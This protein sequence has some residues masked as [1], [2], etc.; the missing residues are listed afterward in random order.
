MR[1]VYPFLSFR[2]GSASFSRSSL[3]HSSWPNSQAMC[4]ALLPNLIRLPKMM[5]SPSLTLIPRERLT[6]SPTAPIP[7]TPPPSSQMTV[8]GFA[9]LFRRILRILEPFLAAIMRGVNPA[10]VTS[11][12][13][14]ASSASATFSLSALPRL[15]RQLNLTPPKVPAK[16]FSSAVSILIN[17]NIN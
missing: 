12:F 14:P 8:L 6:R 7:S 9:L 13:A 16:R 15:L 2:F 5:S 1:G 11:R 4:S 3:T 17:Y 10:N